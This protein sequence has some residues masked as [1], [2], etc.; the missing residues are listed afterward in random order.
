MVSALAGAAMNKVA[1]AR[2][3]KVASLWMSMAFLPLLPPMV[4]LW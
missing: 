3:V 2:P 1:T 4:S